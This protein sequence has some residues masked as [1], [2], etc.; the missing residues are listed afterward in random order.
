MNKNWILVVCFSSVFSLAA[1][2]QGI[3]ETPTEGPII[4][5][6]IPAT[7]P[8]PSPAPAVAAPTEAPVAAPAPTPV[9]PAKPSPAPAVAAPTEAPV[10]V[11]APTP[12][13]PA[14]PSPAPVPSKTYS[15]PNTVPSNQN[16]ALKSTPKNIQEDVVRPSIAVKKIQLSDEQKDAPT[17]KDS[18]D[19]IQ[20]KVLRQIRTS[21]DC[22]PITVRPVN[23]S[24]THE[25]INLSN[26]KSD[27]T[28]NQKIGLTGVS[29]NIEDPSG[30]FLGASSYFASTGDRGGFIGIGLN[31]GYTLL[32]NDLIRLSPSLFVGAAG[33]A[34]VDSVGGGW[35]VRPSFSA[36]LDLKYVW[37]GGGV[38][39]L[40][41]PQGNLDSAQPFA[42]VSIPYDFMFTNFSFDHTIYTQKPASEQISNTTFRKYRFSPVVKIYD[43]PALLKTTDNVS[44]GKNIMLAGVNIEHFMDK[45]WFFNLELLGAFS[46]KVNGYMT[47]MGGPGFSYQL[48]EDLYIEPQIKIGMLGGGKVDVAGGL[49]TEPSLDVV[50]E[51]GQHTNFNAGLGYLYSFGGNF[52]FYTA[53][54]G[55]GVHLD[56]H[57]TKERYNN[58]YRGY[59]L[60]THQQ[61]NWKI[62]ASSSH[63]FIEKDADHDVDLIG[64]GIRYFLTPWLS[65][66]GTGFWPYLGNASGYAA[67]T[68]GPSFEANV[69]GPVGVIASLAAGPAAKAKKMP[70][71]TGLVVSANSGLKFDIT[72]ELSLLSTFGFV[73]YG[74]GGY[75]N[76]FTGGLNYA[77]GLPT[78]KYN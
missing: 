46:T 20:L 61:S 28:Y 5:S 77:F 24:L 3:T 33:G 10:A 71:G 14:K 36:T 21:D 53:H 68:I 50:W 1:F 54:L 27:S 13:A 38:S 4:P 67:G 40:V 48:N 55:M 34:G 70:V 45:N 69:Y 15:T 62:A 30:F 39:Y 73:R 11:P 51:V 25:L 32:I 44:L 75:S 47:L 59:A 26:N 56:A 74:G 7:L 57:E 29:V 58:T 18:P 66:D 72:K 31:T 65:I 76:T 64:L 2:S 49:G 16:S 12:V 37:I 35:I 9:V 60:S 42:Q 52:Q 63:Y 19:K 23:F 41:A 6:E 8:K 43:T 17:Y 78:Y 22:D